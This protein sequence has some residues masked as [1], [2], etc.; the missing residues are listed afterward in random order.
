MLVGY[1]RVGV[2]VA[3][4]L[5]RHDIPFIVVEDDRNRTELPRQQDMPVLW[6]NGTQPESLE[7]ARI[8]HA[9]LL[10]VTL[11]L[12]WEAR[13]VVELARAANPRIVVTVRAHQDAEVDWLHDLDSAG[14]AVMG[15]REVA[16]GIA[17]FA[18]RRMGVPPEAAEA[19]VEVLRKRRVA[20]AA[21]AGLGA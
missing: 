16:L 15:E 2:L 5:R 6:A 21:A 11:P 12:G 20:D 8:G 18:M 19:T 4:A 9:R 7:A 13:R 10:I 14:L 3:A 17:E 1:G